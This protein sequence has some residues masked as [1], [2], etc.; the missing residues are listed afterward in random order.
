MFFLTLIPEWLFY[1]S[2]FAGVIGTALVMVFGGMIPIQYKLG[3]QIISVFLLAIGLFFIGAISNEEKWQLKVKEMEVKVAKQEVAA[4]EMTTEIITKYVDR[5]KI[6]EGK[7]HEIIKK[8]PVYITKESDDKCTINNGFVSVFNS[9]ASQTKIPNT[10]RDV[11]ETA[12]NVKLSTVATTITENY[13]TY[14]QVAEQ[15]KSLQDWI[16]QQKDLDD[17]K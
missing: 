7:T 15:L 3:I 12:S 5:V 10:T 6:V 4:A 1:T 16:T 17:G 8:V 13:G 9:S 2:A 14:Y 11:N